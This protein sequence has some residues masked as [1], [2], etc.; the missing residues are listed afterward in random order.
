M[1]LPRYIRTEKKY[2]TVWFRSLKKDPAK[3]P[4]YFS[5]I[6]AIKKNNQFFVAR[7]IV[8][9]TPKKGKKALVITKAWGSYKSKKVFQKMYNALPD[10]EKTFY[11]QI[12]QLDNS[13]ASVETY[14]LDNL[15]GESDERKQKG[16][17]KGKKMYTTMTP[18]EV[19]DLFVKERKGFAKKLKREHNIDFPF[20]YDE[21]RAENSSTDTQLSLHIKNRCMC[22]QDCKMYLLSFYVWQR[23]FSQ[24]FHR[25]L[26]LLQR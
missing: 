12:H 6:Q 14:D 1:G 22:F 15:I 16:I 20:E 11:E 7:D 9:N 2:G 3:G 26:R 23:V 19:V 24:F 13:T 17:N 18:E 25:P 5:F 10:V 8:I 21:R 4:Q